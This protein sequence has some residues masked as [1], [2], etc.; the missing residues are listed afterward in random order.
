MF[1]MPNTFPLCFVFPKGTVFLDNDR[2]FRKEAKVL[3]ALLSYL[4]EVSN[5][6]RILYHACNQLS[7]KN[8]LASKPC[9]NVKSMASPT[10][11]SLS[12]ILGP[13]C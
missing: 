6:C 5:I 12:V 7:P 11:V 3:T 8:L 9:L 13:S 1:E 4:V 2:L 10:I